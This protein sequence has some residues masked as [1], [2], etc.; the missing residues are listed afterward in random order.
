MSNSN[1]HRF[2]SRLR[3]RAAFA[4][5]AL[6][7]VAAVVACD[8]RGSGLIGTGGT[9]TPDASLRS[10]TVS[11]GTLTPVFD[12]TTTSY[13]LAVTA[14]TASMTVTPTPKAAGSI[15]TVN[16]TVVASGATSPGIP[17]AV[18]STTIV[19]TVTASDALTVRTYAIVVIRPAT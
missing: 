8:G 9:A 12:S 3:R 17:L 19:V 1:T 14:A 2:A 15:V 10:L 4:G 13:A 6:F 7:T 11:S 5:L 16:G 18:G